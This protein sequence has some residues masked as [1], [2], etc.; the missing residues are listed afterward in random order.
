M[1]LHVAKYEGHPAYL[2]IDDDE[3]VIELPTEF[4]RSLIASPNRPAPGAMRRYAEKVRDLCSFLENHDVY[5]Q[6]RIDDALKNLKRPALS[7]F[8]MS[9]QAAG[10]EASTV[11]LAEA[12][13][14]RFTNWLNTEEARYV[15]KRPLYPDNAPLFTPAP[16]KRQPRYLT[17]PQVIQLLQAL[18]CPRR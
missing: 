8:F 4:L 1:Y 5:G 11:R 7:S 10:Q 13:V 14:R 9:L 15:H 17:K 2:F 3:R 6:L 16:A 12:A 18:R